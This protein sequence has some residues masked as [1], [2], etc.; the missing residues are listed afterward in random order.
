MS[1]KHDDKMVTVNLDYDNK[2]NT[3]S[4]LEKG[5]ETDRSFER[6]LLWK[7]DLLI[8]PLVTIAYLLG[9]IDRVNI[10]NAKIAGFVA[11]TGIKE[12]D[13]NNALS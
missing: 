4:S 2:T 12:S 6:K 1:G 13:F 7:L 8:I 10:G 3:S 11:N 5:L 9:N